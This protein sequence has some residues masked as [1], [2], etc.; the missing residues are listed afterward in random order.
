M[1]R[2]SL[3]LSLTFALLPCAPATS[4]AD[5]DGGGGSGGGGNSGG[6][7]SGPGNS[8]GSD[9]SSGDDKDDDDNAESGGPNNNNKRRDSDDA[10]RAVN[11]GLAVSL[12]KL[13]SH[14]NTN[15]PG[16]ILKIEFKK[17]DGTLVYRVKILQTNNKVTSLAL[18]AKTLAK[19]R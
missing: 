18:D 13:K 6:G 8:G 4:F 9:D 2:R 15:Y 17:Q 1:N 19:R 12:K 5:G 7:N 14:L 10:A 11:D 3:L 16:K